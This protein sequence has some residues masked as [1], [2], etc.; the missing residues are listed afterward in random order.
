MT[1]STD[2]GA[3]PELFGIIQDYAQGDHGH[4]VKA[5]RVIAA[6]YLPLF[7]VPPMPDAKQ[8]VEGLLSR[9]G[10]LL[11]DPETGRLEPASVDAVVS[12]ATSRLDEEDLKWGAG[13]LLSVMDA[14]GRRTQSEGYE[15]YVLDADEVLD[16]LETILAAD[17]M[18]DVME[19]IVDEG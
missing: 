17:I 4:Q 3:F 5:L 16:G 1:E 6:A 15:T 18:E 7:E 8:V 10:F 2:G 13:C 19:D 11:T 12:V 14:L 9:N